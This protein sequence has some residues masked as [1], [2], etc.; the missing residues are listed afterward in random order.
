MFT[1][2]MSECH[3]KTV[4]IYDVDES[5]LVSLVKFAYTARITLTTDNVQT[6]LYACSILQ[7]THLYC[8][9][10]AYFTSQ[11]QSLLH[12]KSPATK[13]R[14]PQIPQWGLHPWTQLGEFRP[15][16]PMCVESK[17][18]VKLNCGSQYG[19]C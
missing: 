19:R 4:T 11:M 16:N 6:L 3:K 2:E 12:K 10:T 15:L 1:S 8:R 18:L 7:V 17:K 13:E 5:A 14:S 9:L